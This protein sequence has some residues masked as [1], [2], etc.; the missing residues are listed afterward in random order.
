M[1]TAG[2]D[3]SMGSG[4][5]PLAHAKLKHVITK[6][7]CLSVSAQFFRVHPFSVSTIFRFRS[8]VLFNFPRIIFMNMVIGFVGNNEDI[9][10]VSHKRLYVCWYVTPVTHTYT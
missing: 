5:F 3:S 7:E 9:G 2:I 10:K 8:T 1:H 4:I 6:S